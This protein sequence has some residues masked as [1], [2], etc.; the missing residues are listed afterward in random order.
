[1][2]HPVAESPGALASPTR[3]GTDVRLQL[4]GTMRA[5]TW[6]ALG[7]FLVSLLGLFLCAVIGGAQQLANLF[8]WGLLGA[9]VLAVVTAIAGILKLS[10][11]NTMSVDGGD[12]VIQRARGARRIPS[13]EIEEGWLSP[14]ENRVYLRTQRGDLYSASVTDHAHGQALL[15][16]AGLDASKRT[17]RT[18]LGA[19]DFL[20]V[21][22]WLVGPMTAVPIAEAFAGALN[23]RGVLAI[24][25]AITLFVLQFYLVRQLFGPAHLVIGADGIIV[26]QRLRA[27]F[28][29]FDDI[30]SITTAPDNVTLHLG[31]GSLV[32][33]RARHLDDAAQAAIQARVQAALAVRRARSAEPSALAELDRGQ[34]SG[35]AWR[36]ALAALLDQDRGYRAARLTRD[37]ILGV[38]E[39]PAA[40]PG[41]RIGAALALA[42]SGDQDAVS[43]IR[44]AAGSSANQKVRIALE[45][46]ACGDIEAAAIDEA[47]AEEES[48]RAAV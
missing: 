44:I 28:I 35:A 8:G 18:R 26:K 25:L 34:R 11:G 39:N 30:R 6:G 2:F 33:A 9:P 42:E 32:R 46:I 5:A 41:R 20:N 13:T 45:K 47:A 22:S 40:P 37:Q 43:R 38:L 31:D 16:R 12:V 15:E 27:R 3:P 4:D 29:S 7:L 23:M 14:Q 17:L 21:M 48:R 24:P 10:A 1:M 36:A 19:V